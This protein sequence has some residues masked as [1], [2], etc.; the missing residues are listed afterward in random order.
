MSSNSIQ[1]DGFY[2][3]RPPFI[4]HRA[5]GNFVQC[6]INVAMQQKTL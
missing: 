6:K 2:R 1:I 5:V 4:N 3:F